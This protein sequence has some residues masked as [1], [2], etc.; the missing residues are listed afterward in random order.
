MFLQVTFLM[1][2]LTDLCSTETVV[3]K[4]LGSFL[5]DLLCLEIYGDDDDGG[6]MT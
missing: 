3:S 2:L 5:F 1:Y 4:L 6:E